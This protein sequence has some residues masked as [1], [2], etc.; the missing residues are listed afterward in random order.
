MQASGLT[1]QVAVQECF[2]TSWLGL[3]HGNVCVLGTATEPPLTPH[4]QWC[5]PVVYPHQLTQLCQAVCCTRCPV[6][7]L[8]RVRYAAR[9]QRAAVAAVI[10]ACVTPPT[11][12]CGCCAVPAAR[13]CCLPLTAVGGWQ[14]R[15]GGG[16]WEQ[17]AHRCA[18]CLEGLRAQGSACNLLC[19]CWMQCPVYVSQ[20]SNR[21]SDA[22]AA[23]TGMSWLGT[24]VIMHA[25][26]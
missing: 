16:C 1:A 26:A 9:K 23:H 2:K 15:E 25:N 10:V 20:L 14:G 13:F 21:A 4:I 22:H 6:R 24:S 12:A 17:W 8:D 11:A 3:V 19:I 18:C 7:L 5:C